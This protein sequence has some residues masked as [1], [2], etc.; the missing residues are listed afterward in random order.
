MK[1]LFDSIDEAIHQLNIGCSVH[2]DLRRKLLALGERESSTIASMYWVHTP[3]QHLPLLLVVH[4]GEGENEK[5]FTLSREKL[6][7]YIP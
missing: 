3:H 5:V 6:I 1:H 7:D 2:P 4:T